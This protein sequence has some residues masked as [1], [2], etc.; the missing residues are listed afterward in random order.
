MSSLRLPTLPRT[1]VLILI[2]LMMPYMALEGQHHA[3]N[4]GSEPSSAGTIAGIPEEIVHRAIPLRRD[5]TTVSHPIR[6]KSDEARSFHEQGLTYL[7]LFS[8]LNAARSFFTALQLDPDLVATRTG[9][10]LSYAALGDREKATTMMNEAEARTNQV[11]EAERLWVSAYAAL[12][13]LHAGETGDIEALRARIGEGA[14]SH[15]NDPEL[16]LVAAQVAQMEE[17]VALLH[18]VLELVPDHVGAHHHLVHVYEDD[19]RTLDLAV[20][21]GAA[22]ARLAPSV[23]HARH[24][25]GHNL[26]RVG[27]AADAVVEFEAAREIERRLER[28]EGVPVRHDWHHPHNLLLL[29]MSRH[30][31]GRIGEAEH[32]FHELINLPVTGGEAPLGRQIGLLDFYLALGR[33]EDALTVAEAL[34]SSSNPTRRGARKLAM[35]LAHLGAGDPDAALRGWSEATAAFPANRNPLAFHGGLLEILLGSDSDRGAESSHELEAPHPRLAE[36]LNGLMRR[37]GPDAWSEAHLRMEVFA[38]MAAAVGRWE[39]VDQVADALVTHDPGY[40]GGYYWRGRVAEAAGDEAG[41]QSAAERARALW[42]EADHSFSRAATP[43]AAAPVSPTR[44]VPATGAPPVPSV[45]AARAGASIVIDGTLDDPAWIETPPITGLVQTE[46]REGHA[47][48]EPTEVRILYDD[49]ALYVA[50]RLYD[51][52]P[53]SSRVARRDAR[54]PDSD[55]FSVSLDSNG[56]G[57]TA[58]RF[59]VNPDGVRGD[60][61]L[62]RNGAVDPAWNPVWEAATSVDAEGWTV[63]MRIP[64]SQLR[65]DGDGSGRWGIQIERT[66]R[67]K[68]EISVLSFTPQREAGGIA[69]FALLEGIEGL[70][71]G[72]KLELLPYAVSRASTGA[73]AALPGGSHAAMDVGMDLRY[74]ITPA[75]TLDL[76]ARPDFGQV[77]LDPA[78]VNLSAFELWFPENRPFFVEGADVFRPGYRGWI[79]PELFYTRRIGAAPQGRMPSGTVSQARLEPVPILGAGKL[80][81]RTGGGWSVGAMFAATQRTDAPFEDPEGDSGVATL[82]PSTTYTVA[83]LRRE[84]RGG[85]TTFGAMGTAVRRGDTD[86]PGLA[87]LNDAGYTASLDFTHEFAERRWRLGGEFQGSRVEG[88]P[89]AMT[90]IQRSGIRALQRPDADHLSVDSLATHL[91]GWAAQLE[92]SRQ[93]GEHWRGSVHVGAVSP[94]HE[95]NDLGFQTS[96]DRMTA[97]T[98]LQFR[99]DQPGDYFQRWNVSAS[100]A[101]MANFAGDV[102]A[103][104]G[105]VTFNG[106]F[107]N[108]WNLL[109]QLMKAPSVKDDRLTRGGPMSRTPGTGLAFAWLRSDSRRALSGDLLTEVARDDDGGAR[110]RAQGNLTFQPSPRWSM[111]LSSAL[112]RTTT[113]A[114]YLGAVPDPAADHTYGARYLFGALDQRTFELGG[115][116][117]L[118]LRP[119]LTLELRA[120]G[121]VSSGAFDEPGELARPGTRTIHRYG[122]DLGEVEETDGGRRIHLGSESGDSFLLPHRD[123]TFRNLRGGAVLRWDWHRGSTIYAVWQ[124]DRSGA[125]GEADFQLG[126]NL[127]TFGDLPVRHSFQIK[128][129]YWLNP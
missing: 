70:A 75:F 79:A 103:A 76:A 93:A 6:A 116:L 16:L 34:H 122:R 64:F 126:R 92:L 114:H 66:L 45:R 7:H 51:S 112:S 56:D 109:V 85:A 40:A 90:T 95:V 21:H 27:R 81:G 31:Q 1:P 101:G 49:E 89:E 74:R 41:A 86:V 107:H 2:F 73:A 9:L 88:R 67:R 33:W 108:R 4:G 120:R 111:G 96:A 65:L 117:D 5:L 84:L 3:P 35:A 8:Y 100:G 20:E 91:T 22:L 48:T 110:R 17:R 60:E 129:S 46:P 55:W 58:V 113:P 124:Q 128:A 97:V 36:I 125:V 78:Q 24:M 42:P 119:E 104:S 98:E 26:R 61:A 54:L 121:L 53:P 44:E 69:R 59:R 82:E 50:A 10:A 18:R 106:L 15:P 83:R 87:H 38:T 30:H 52:E 12:V 105:L 80:T 63:E 57:M 47:P 28:E 32:T 68:N 123:F 127:R 43:T 19:L 39:L 102:V 14:S 99:R 25:Y 77:E 118:A 115:R 29:A 23:A 72:G 37:S 11:G 71:P 94:G 62:S 13:R